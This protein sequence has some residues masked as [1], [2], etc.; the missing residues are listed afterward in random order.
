MR[1]GALPAALIFAA[2]SFALS[3][4]PRQVRAPALLVAATV[5]LAATQLSLDASREEAVYFTCWASVIL[6]AASVHLR[7]GLPERAALTLALICGLAAGAV[8][9]LVGSLQNLVAAFPAA[10]VIVPAS[11]L[12]ATGRGIAVKVVSSWLIAIAML[13]AALPLTPTPGYEPD[14]LE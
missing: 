6:A 10:L 1:G 5:A 3:F 2:L 11:W 7:A 4:A 13:A 9:S 12:V 8:I 14:H